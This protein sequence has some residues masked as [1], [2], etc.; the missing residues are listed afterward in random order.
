MTHLL[1]KMIKQLDHRFRLSFLVE[2]NDICLRDFLAQQQI[3]KRTLTAVKFDGGHLSVNGV[4]RDVRHILQQGDSVEVIFPPEQPS[5][6]LQ[7]E[8]GP[9]QIVYED[10][11]ILIVNKQ[12]NQ[13]TIPSRDHRNGTVANY[14]AGKFKR[15]HLPATV[16][17]VTRLDYNTSGL[18][19]IAK[20]RHIH[21]LLS[22]QLIAGNF[23]REYEAIVEGAV[24]EEQFTIEKN[25]GRKSTSIIEREICEDGQFA[26]TDVKVVRI[27][28]QN[29]EYLS[30]V[31]LVLH[32]GRTHQIRVHLASIG[33]PLA[34]DDLYGGSRATIQ[35]QALHCAFLRF[36][37]PIT[38]EALAFSS[39]LPED[40]QRLIDRTS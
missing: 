37:H 4:E 34:G 11:S 39:P 40:M 10:E 1:I 16:H 14:V 19:C 18:L 9:L 15:E 12:A 36:T 27:V 30:I 32:T 26:K 35:R 8:D 29:N 24:H 21:H 20:N 22:S 7:A 3:S 5:V 33:H 31:R 25:I 28:H 38:N 6:G 13:S 2:R 23:H 17:V